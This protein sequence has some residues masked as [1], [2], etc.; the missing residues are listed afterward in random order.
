MSRRR[1]AALPSNLPAFVELTHSFGYAGIPRRQDAA[2]T[3][4]GPIDTS[5]EFFSRLRRSQKILSAS[6]G[7]FA[8]GIRSAGDTG[9]IEPGSID[10]DP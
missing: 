4:D 7:S 1:L 6:T 8:Q 10:H 3:T 5:F 9:T 2:S